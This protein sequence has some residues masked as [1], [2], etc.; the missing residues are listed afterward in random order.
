MDW[1]IADTSG[2]RKVWFPRQQLSVLLCS[3]TNRCIVPESLSY[4]YQSFMKD[5]FDGCPSADHRYGSH[6][7]FT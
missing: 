3:Q 1:L 6:E 4:F 2:W 5:E 7:V